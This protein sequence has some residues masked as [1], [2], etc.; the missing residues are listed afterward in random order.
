MAKLILNDDEPSINPTAEELAKVIVKRLGLEPRKKG[1]TEHMHAVL[2]ELYEREKLAGQTKDPTKAVITV[3]EMAIHAHISRQTMYEY[4]GRWTAL[5]FIIKATYIDQERKVIIGYKLNGNTLES[6]F[7]KV[8]AKISN[9]LQLTEKYLEELQ[10]LI[11]NEKISKA[12][13]E[14]H[15]DKTEQDER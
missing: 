1:S 13:R 3:E 12:Q 4:L 15:A 2:V 11:K 10:K 14:K 8:R 7:G 6:A 5:D 9:N